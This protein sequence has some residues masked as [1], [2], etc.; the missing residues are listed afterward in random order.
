M[1]ILG[2]G[3]DIIECL[4]IAQMIDRHGE[5]F[6]NRVFTEPEVRF[7]QSRRQTTQHFAG[8]WAAKQAL[9]KALGLARQ[10]GV[11]W[12]E[13]EI[14]PGLED[15]PEAR[16]HGAVLARARLLAA[17]D[18]HVSISYCRA[19]ATALAIVCRSDRATL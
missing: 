3:T 12:H 17:G 11:R 15:R 8:R 19:Y 18:V 7:C 10:S 9:L 14:L 16:L 6:I 1:S 5:L 4:R 13:L 2:L